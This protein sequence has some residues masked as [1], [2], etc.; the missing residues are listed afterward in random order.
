[1]KRY[2]YLF[3][4]SVGLIGFQQQAD[5]LQVLDNNYTATV[6]ASYSHAGIGRSMGMTFDDTGNLYVTQRGDAALS[7]SN[8]AI[9]KVTPG[10][11]ASRW[12]ENIDGPRRIVWGGGTAYGNNLYVTESEPDEYISQIS[13]SGTRTPFSQ[14]ERTGE[15]EDTVHP[16]AIDRSGNYGGLMYTATRG[17]QKIYDISTSGIESVFSPFPPQPTIGGPLD[18]AFDPGT[19]YGGLLYMAIDSDSTNGIYSIDVNG[20]ATNFASFFPKAYELEFDVPGGIFGG[21]MLVHNSWNI[22]RIDPQE[23]VQPLATPDLPLIMTMGPDGALY[24]SETDEIL[25]QVTISRITL[26]PEPATLAL[27]LAGGFYLKKRKLR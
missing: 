12:V 6:Y 26:V 1:M 3:I 8:G 14:I 23:N 27:L 7:F 18:L 10:G 13:T 22:V 24:V 4:I 5:A 25:G 16:L 15:D 2:A 11:T 19:D 21:Q 17:T 9:Y 20:N